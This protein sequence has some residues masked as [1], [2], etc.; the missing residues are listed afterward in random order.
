MATTCSARALPFVSQ[1]GADHIINYN[2][3]K[4][5]LAAENGG[6][7]GFDCVFNC[8]MD[9]DAWKNVQTEGLVV[10][11]GAYVSLTHSEAGMNPTAHQPRFRFAAFY[12]AH[13]DTDDLN[14]ALKLLQE[15]RIKVPIEEVF[16]FTQQG[17]AAAFAKVAAGKS[18]G[19][20]IIKIV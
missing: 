8:A 6:H 17:V 19:K 16:P 9:P 7:S 5:W 13:H 12:P 15:D 1:Y 4:W 20:N 2:E 3:A 18:L 14:E 10:H 11:G